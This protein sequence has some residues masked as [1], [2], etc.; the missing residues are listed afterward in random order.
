MAATLSAGFD[1]LQLQYRLL[2]GLHELLPDLLLALRVLPELLEILILRLQKLVP[3]M[4]PQ[5]SHGLNP[6]QGFLSLVGCLC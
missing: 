6:I 2:P 4:L 3:H 5:D 1:R